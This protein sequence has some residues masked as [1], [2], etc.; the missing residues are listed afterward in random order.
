MGSNCAVQVGDVKKVRLDEK[1]AFS[2]RF[3]DVKMDEIKAV[4]KW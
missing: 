4:S 2:I 1:R 3:S